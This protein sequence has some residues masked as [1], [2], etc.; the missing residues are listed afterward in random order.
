MIPE[1]GHFA[2]ILALLV[3]IVQSTLPLA[4]AALG[5]PRLMALARPAARAQFFLVLVAFA[6]LAAAFVGNDFSV[7]NVATNSNS[8][9][10]LHYRLAATWGS[11]EGSLLLW[12]LMLTGWTFA[13]ALFSRHLPPVFL[14]RV[15]SVMGLVSVGFLLF[16]L[17]T[18]NPF[19]RLVPPAP[20]GRDLNPL[21]QDP[22]MV[23]HPP[24]L[25]MGYVGFSVAFAFA[26][27]A[28]LGGRLDATWA[29]WSRPW[30]T[31]AWAFLT[32]GIALSSGWAYYTLGW[33]GW[34]FWDPVEN[35]SFMPWLS[36]TALI[37]SLA[38][39]EK[40]GAFKSWTVL[41]AIFAFSLSL[42]GTFL[43]RSGVLT[44]VHAFAKAPG[45]GVFVLVF[46]TLVIGGSLALF[47]YRA[48]KVGLGGIFGMISRE[49]A[50]LANNILLIVAM[51]SVLLG[52]LYPLF[53]DALN[54]GKISVGPPY[55]DAVFY[56]LLAPAVF[57][58]G[59]GP[60]ARW[61]KASL[62]SLWTRLRWAFGVA[63]VA[64]VLLPF[65]LGRW[66]PLIAAGLF[67]ALWIAT[68]SVVNLRDRLVG[69]HRK[70]LL[71]KLAANSPS[72]YG[73]LLAH[74]G[75]A[76]F[77]AGVTL[78]KGSEVEQDGR[79]EVR[80]N[81]AVGAYEC[82]FLGVHPG[83]GPNYRAVIGTVEV[84]RN[85]SL[86]ETLHPEKRIY[87]ASGQTM[88]IAAIAVGV[89]GDRYVSLGEPLA[90]DDLSG[91]WG[92]RIYL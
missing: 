79:L 59:V 41:L 48:G 85:G 5:A 45:R 90:A 9:L 92:V 43:V 64:A 86:L 24:M 87:N 74:L 10:P 67:L 66:S 17:F 12:S 70:G 49:S 30:T 25:Y 15:I 60:V 51:A 37:H 2:L 14:A 4:G 71:A 78:V 42:L 63:I 72:Y 83:P 75:V 35:A 6:C 18:S 8:E 7:Q 36:G 52:T 29:R 61:S 68:S 11:H 53:L 1:L 22:G 33:G 81:V 40:R 84:R 55:F 91:P 44:S 34:W 54:L 16:L 89:F 65:S 88:T 21:L 46:L 19:A 80:Q 20:E 77:I 56:P 69:S 58:M 38:V 82:R 32:I 28:L 13:V 31:V 76:V 39:T 3:A 23:I 62:P 47:A 57:L 50:L 26:I 27:A 73:M